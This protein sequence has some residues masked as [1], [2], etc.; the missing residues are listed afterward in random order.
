[1]R[2][3]RDAALEGRHLGRD[4]GDP[5]DRPLPARAPADPRGDPRPVRPRGTRGRDHG[6]QRA[7]QARRDRPRRRRPLPAHPDRLGA[8]RGERRL[9]RPH[10]QGA[11]DPAPPGGGRHQDRPVRLRRRGRRRRPRGPRPGRGVRGHRPAG[12]RGLPVAVGD[13]ARR[14][15]RDRGD[16][17][18][19]R[20]PHRRAD[21]ILRPGRPHQRPAPRPDD[22]HSRAP[23]RGQVDA[24]AGLRAGRRHQAQ[25]GDRAVQPGNGAERDHDAAA[26]GRGAGAPDTRCAPGR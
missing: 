16:R 6:R 4:R 5:A 11:R 7:H 9:L 13:H 10:R 22:R 23:R 8:D 15:G 2:A 19:R 26:V 3:R 24:G 17:Q 12:Q 18:P 21:R 25:H 1:M 20:R 14:A